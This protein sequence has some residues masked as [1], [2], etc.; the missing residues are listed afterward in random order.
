MIIE[1]IELYNFGSYED[2]NLFHLTSDDPSKRIVIV[3]G[4]NGAGKTTLFTAMQ[5]CFYGHISFGFKTA[6]KRYL[7]EIYHLMNNR[8]RLDEAKS[9]YVKIV[10]SERRIETDQYE[11]TRSWTWS[12]GIIS[13]AFSVTRNGV[14][15][16]EDASLNF[17]NYLLHLIPPELHKLYFFD[18]EKI[19]DFFLNEQHNNIKDALL[20]LSGND[21]YEILYSSL[22]HLLNG[23][24]PD[25]MSIA[26]NYA[27]Q[28]EILADRTKREAALLSQQQEISDAIEQLENDLRREKDAYKLNGGVTLEE[29]KA[30]Q[31]N[32]K[33]E[34]E[35]RERLNWKLRTTATDILPFLIVKDTLFHV[36]SQIHSERELNT[37]NILRNSL[38]TPRFKRCL[39]AAVKKTSS[40]DYSSDAAIL[41]SAI[42]AFF[43]NRE[44]ETKE[45]ILKLSEDETITILNKISVIEDFDI[46]EIRKDRRRIE[47]SSQ[48]STELR[49]QLQKSSIENFEEHLK[50]VT[51]ITSRIEQLK[52]Q[53]KEISDSLLALQD[54]IAALRKTLSSSRKALEMEL[55][56][57]SVSALSDRVLLLVEE[58]QDEQYKK[59]LCAVEHDL[60]EKFKDLIRKDRF[61]DH[62]YLDS[63]FSLHLVR[64]QAVEVSALRLSVKNHGIAALKNSLKDIGYH[65]LLD[66][67]NTCES[68]LSSAL[69]NCTANTI[70]LPIELD[71]SHFSNGEKQILVMSLYWA[72][73]NQSHNELPFIIDTP[74]ARIDTEHRAN[75]TERFFKELPGQLFVLSTNEELRH[76]HIATLDQQIANIYMLEYGDDKRTR[77]LED[78]YFE[79]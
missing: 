66:H 17:Q 55:K 60:N 2:R 59:I 76:Q 63:T 58:L 68:D 64:N 49:E 44:F 67:L 77:I 18:G 37:Y 12:N 53:H 41:M 40:Q 1:Q 6:G 32:L 26:Q 33:D 29:W 46:S 79:V 73:M 27:D 34:E 42:Q 13:E 14:Q 61:V 7:K 16:D 74:F 31:R 56:K 75:I 8:A 15:L 43:E 11:I 25:N 48:R 20:V 3:G 35:R 24:G 51:E 52:H 30:I 19:A 38:S 36:R 39:S 50:Q 72:I 5:V 10:F 45:P 21:T 47:K 69:E 78:N 22:R 57:Q 70:V 54:E 71:Y 28:K 62:I 4:K 65:A 9:A 23:T